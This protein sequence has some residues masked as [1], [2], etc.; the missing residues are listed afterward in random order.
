MHCSME[1]SEKFFDSLCKK[2]IQFL[3]NIQKLASFCYQFLL[4]CIFQKNQLSVATFENVLKL[5]F[6]TNM[7][8]S[9]IV[10]IEISST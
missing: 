6:I 1:V 7:P 4:N 5:C 10:L 3:C 9:S 8:P 2:S